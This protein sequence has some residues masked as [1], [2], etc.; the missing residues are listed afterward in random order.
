MW[1]HTVIAF[2]KLVGMAKKDES[3]QPGRIKTMW[4]VFQMTRKLDS[5]A[6]PLMILAFAVPVAIVTVLTLLFTESVF[7]QI[8]WIVTSVVTGVLL[9]LIVMGRRAEAAAMKQMEGRPGAVGSVLKN[10]LRGAWQTSEMPVAVNPKTQEAVYRAIGRPGI[11]LIAEGAEGR[12]KKMV[13]D[14]QRKVGRVVPNVPVTVLQVSGESEVTLSKLTKTMRKLP[15]KIS[16]P[17]VVQV[18]NRLASMGNLNLPIPKGIDPR[19]VRS[20]RP[21]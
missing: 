12:T 16:K 9:A 18:T 13:L 10:G 15:R 2:S 1:Q 20:G 11:V 21:R 8:L 7:L 6:L 14:E 19:K 5:L 3:K 17:E 4:Q